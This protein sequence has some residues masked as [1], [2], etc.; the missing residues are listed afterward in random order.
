MKHQIQMKERNERM[1]VLS[2]Q[3]FFHGPTISPSPGGRAIITH[4]LTQ[5]ML[6]NGIDI[7]IFPHDEA[8]GEDILFKVNKHSSTLAYRSLPRPNEIT[9]IKNFMLALKVT[10]ARRSLKKFLKP[11]LEAI[12]FRRAVDEFS[13]D[14]V[15][16]HNSRLHTVSSIIDKGRRPKIISTEHKLIEPKIVREYANYDKVVFVSKFQKDEAQTFSPSISSRSEVI[17]NYASQEYHEHIT[18]AALQ[19]IVFLGSLNTINKGFDVLVDSI[20]KYG[21][22]Y[23]YSLDVIGDGHLKPNFEKSLISYLPNTKVRFLGRLSKRGNIEILKDASLLIVPSRTEGFGN[24]YVEALCMGVPVIGF[25]KTI[26]E[27]NFILE[28]K[29]GEPFDAFKEGPGDLF[30]KSKG[31]LSDPLFT[32]GYRAELSERSRKIFNFD[33]YRLD[34]LRLY[35]QLL[36][37]NH[38]SRVQHL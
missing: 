34:Y 19:K 22:P 27:L 5:S 3:P 8:S 31:I 10:A 25:H 23:N 11:L 15:H 37:D 7:R 14:I 4:S 21:L 16:M 32:D 2:I 18:S 35:N 26:N 36:N 9:K 17:Y 6:N 28:M 24:V 38:S 12:A 30:N 1:R 20:Q 13:P 29:V 33:R